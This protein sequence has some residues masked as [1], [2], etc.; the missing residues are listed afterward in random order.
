MPG[1]EPTV[2]E[3]LAPRPEAVDAALIDAPR[4]RAMAPVDF[5]LDGA[6]TTARL[7]EAFA[8]RGAA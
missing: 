6:A 7:V 5:A 2:F 3:R 1:A 4:R 8:A